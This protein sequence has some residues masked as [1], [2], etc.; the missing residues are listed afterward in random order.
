MNVTYV[1]V[2]I[3]WA[4]NL[5]SNYFSLQQP[6]PSFTTVSKLWFFSVKY[7]INSGVQPVPD[8]ICWPQVRFIPI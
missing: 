8:L 4:K 2:Q 5:V 7:V 1:P 6:D 3:D